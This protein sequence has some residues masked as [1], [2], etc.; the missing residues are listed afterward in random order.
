MGANDKNKIFY[1][2]MCLNSGFL[3]LAKDPHRFITS[4]LASPYLIFILLE[5]GHH[6]RAFCREIIST[7]TDIT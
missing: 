2:L 6:K 1:R 5:P 3:S 4:A 7:R